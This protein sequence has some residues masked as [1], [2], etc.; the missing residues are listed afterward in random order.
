MF[1]TSERSAGTS[2]LPPVP[3]SAGAE[4]RVA[5][6]AVAAPDGRPGPPDAAVEAAAGPA[7]AAVA[8]RAL[9]FAA[10]G[11]AGVAAAQPGARVQ[12]VRPAEGVLEA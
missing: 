11:A 7:E 9:L 12:H 4:E 3:V 8:A 10:P 1:S 6:A 5:A 2:W